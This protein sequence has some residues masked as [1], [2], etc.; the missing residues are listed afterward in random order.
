MVQIARP[1]S[2]TLAGAWTPTGAASLHAALAEPV[3][4]DASFIASEAD[5]ANSACE[6]AVASLVDPSDDSG[7]VLRWRHA[8][9]AAGG[10]SIDLTVELRQGTTVIAT[11]SFI[12]IGDVWTTGTLVLSGAAAANI[13]DYSDLR[14][15]FIADVSGADLARAAHVSWAELETPGADATV[16]ALEAQVASLEQQVADLTT[17]NG[18]KR[19]AL[20]STRAGALTFLARAR[21]RE[22]RDVERIIR[23]IRRAA[24][25]GLDE[26]M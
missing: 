17:L 9:S 5:P 6:V 1:E 22:Q 3:P 20:T 23:E 11:A 13:S 21:G 12:D 14:L 8:K 26:T 19:T 2:T 15:R 18:R 25:H 24:E 10:N 7:H 4:D 16:A